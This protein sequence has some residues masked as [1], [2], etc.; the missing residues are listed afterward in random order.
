MGGEVIKG[1]IEKVYEYK[2]GNLYVVFVAIKDDCLKLVH[3]SEKPYN[4]ERK[5]DQEL[6]EASTLAEIQITGM[7]QPN[8]KGNKLG[9][10]LVG[11]NLRLKTIEQSENK[12]TVVQFYKEKEI[13]QETVRHSVIRSRWGDSTIGWRPLGATGMHDNDCRTRRAR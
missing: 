8:H 7:N 3:C 12:L 2:I 5:L 11:R 1:M 13:E 6:I 10:T 4:A 9:N